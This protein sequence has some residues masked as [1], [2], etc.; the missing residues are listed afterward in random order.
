MRQL[1]LVARRVHSFCARLN[2]GLSAVVLVLSLVPGAA[3]I[4][5]NAPPVELADDPTGAAAVQT[6]ATG[7][8][9]SPSESP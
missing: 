8:G 5:R 7:F 6:A 4:L 2:A 3:W 1:A 9:I